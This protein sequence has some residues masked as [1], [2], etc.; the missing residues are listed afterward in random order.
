MS[1][2]K[3]SNKNGNWYI[4]EVIEKCEPT[5]RNEKKE[6]R[7][8]ITWGN[9][10]LIKADSPEEAFA[11]AVKIGEEGN[12][13]FTNENG[14]EMEWCFVGIADLIPVYED[15]EDGAEIM[16]TDY[17][18]ISNKRAEKIPRTKEDILRSLVPKKH[19]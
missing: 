5:Q 12:Q 18:Y 10:H 19:G 4:A 3:I 13:Q 6:L 9:H 1:Q 11:K 16:W 2:E 15:I 8:V 17:G 14:V 7:R